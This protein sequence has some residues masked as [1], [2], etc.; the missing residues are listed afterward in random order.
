MGGK[1][2]T[3]KYGRNEADCAKYKNEGRREKNKAVKIARHLSKAPWDLVAR[4]A[5]E[6]LPQ[7]AR[8]GN[9]IPEYR[10]MPETGIWR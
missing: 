6:A 7:I 8:R 3:K 5:F 10:T 9:V 2:G 1:N 4:A